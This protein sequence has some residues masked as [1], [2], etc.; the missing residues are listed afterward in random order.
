[1]A[2]KKEMSAG[3]RFEILG[4]NKA[5]KDMASLHHGLFLISQGAN[6]ASKAVFGLVQTFKFADAA[7]KFEEALVA[8]GQ[9]SQATT[10][11]LMLLRK[12]AI[13]A[14]LRT[15]FSPQEAVE[16]LQTLA[17]M[18][19]KARESIALLQP[20]LD[21]AAGSLGQ[22]GLAQAAQAV[23]GTMRAFRLET[24][25]ATEITDKLLRITQLTNFQASDFGSGLSKAAGEAG[26]FGQTIDDTLILMGLLRNMNLNASVSSTAVRNAVRRLAGDARVRNQV[27]GLGIQIYDKLTGKMRP[28]LDILSDLDSK[29]KTMSQSQKDLLSAKIF[30]ARSIFAA[31][32]FEG[33]RFTKTLKDGSTVILKG[34]DAIKEYRKE[35]AKSAGTARRFREALLN[36]FEG[37]KKLL[38]GIVQTA[39][40]LAG[41]P[42]VKVL[43]PII[44]LVVDFANKALTA[45]R[46]L[47][48][49]V[50]KFFAALTL[51]VT[52]F[53]TFGTALIGIKIAL[54]GVLTIMAALNITFVGIAFTVIALGALFVG[55][56]AM[57]GLIYAAFKTNFGGVTEVAM[58]VKKAIEGVWAV[59]TAWKDGTSTLS[60]EM[61]N[62]LRKSGVLDFSIRLGGWLGRLGQWFKDMYVIGRQLGSN[63]AKALMPL[64][65]SVKELIVVLFAAGKRIFEAIVGPFDQLKGTRKDMFSFGEALTKIFGWIGAA[66]SFVAK[67]ISWISS[68]IR[69]VIQPG[70]FAAMFEKVVSVIKKVWDFLS[71]IVGMFVNIAVALLPAV[72]TILSAVW[73]VIKAVGT[74]VYALVLGFVGMLDFMSGGGGILPVIQTIASV[75]TV[76][77]QVVAIIVRVVGY[78]AGLFIKFITPVI[79]LIGSALGMILGVIVNIVKFI[80]GGLVSALNWVLIKVNAML[81]PFRWLFKKIQEI[82]PFASKTA[83]IQKKTSERGVASQTLNKTVMDVLG[84]KPVDQPLGPNQ[85]QRTLPPVMGAPGGGN[86]NLL[87]SKGLIGG[88]DQADDT[89]KQALK[90]LADNDDNK[91][92]ILERNA[93]ASEML[94]KKLAGDDDFQTIISGAIATA[95]LK[96]KTDG[97]GTI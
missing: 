75:F 43:K 4:F 39:A 66:A 5:V 64:A 27:E 13:E 15:Q 14:G 89:T 80:A 97:Y 3:I 53:I 38:R 84:M 86:Q 19:F 88:Q 26:Q 18:G 21:L 6:V 22:L 29:T 1:M 54:A 7:G 81:A 71:P 48:A 91:T 93:A 73:D 34:M 32:A 47:P 52:T 36:T 55:L 85:K 76:I 69:T 51:I 59:M 45:F 35:L 41:E 92:R 68:A 46:A 9:I 74:A 10:E 77:V 95:L 12:A 16:G 58:K 33:A 40:V 65:T 8:V 70:F 87:L 56:I 11:E 25:K 2:A 90:K 67:G 31:G 78:L 62:D 63:L 24:S 23:A 28:V 20:V 30:G 94:A 79:F 61:A 82:N 72:F 50:K 96:A 37:Q 42:F 44:R 49:P 57:A 83:E 60:K 17:A